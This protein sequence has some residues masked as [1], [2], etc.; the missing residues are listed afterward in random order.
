VARAGV[1][2]VIAAI[3]AFTA[4]EQVDAVGPW[5]LELLRYAPF[6]VVL[7]PAVMALVISFKLGWRWVIASAATTV[8]VLT[9]TM[10]LAWNSSPNPA[11]SD[12]QGIRLMTYNIKAYLAEHR[13]GGF[14]ELAGEIASH[15]PDI[16]VMQDADHV[17]NVAL[18]G[19]D[20]R[21]IDAREN[22]GVRRLTSLQNVFVADQYIVAS[23]FL[24]L[25]CREHTVGGAGQELYYVRCSVRLPNGSTVQIATAHLGSPR[26]GLNAARRDGLDG[27][28]EWQDNSNHRLAQARALAADLKS[29]ERPLILA[30]DLNAIQASPVIRTLSAIG[31]RDA[32]ATGGRGYGYTYGHDLKLRFSFLRIDHVMASPEIE[33]LH[34]DRGGSTASQHRP[35]I[36]DLV[37]R[38]R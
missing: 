20:A 19:T 16:V 34:A 32:F 28:D 5:W 37:L 24:L 21:G 2:F 11:G 14:E 26:S 30:G 9:V 23:R 35:V 22:A 8:L 31:L 25:D 6:P 12:D 38:G 33:V 4:A 17:A 27:A 29:V 18:K 36:A 15:D 3:V 7:I 10:G 13:S 1:A